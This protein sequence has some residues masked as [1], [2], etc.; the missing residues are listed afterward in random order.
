[1]NKDF[2][3]FLLFQLH[4]LKKKKNIPDDVKCEN[5]IVH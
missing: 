2:I 5:I 3:L 4:C 1:M